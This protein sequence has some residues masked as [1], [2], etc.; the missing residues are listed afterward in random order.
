MEMTGVKNLTDDKVVNVLRQ[1]FEIVHV[2]VHVLRP[3]KIIQGW[4][5]IFIKKFEWKFSKHVS[6]NTEDFELL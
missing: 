6:K 1:I 4:N 3:S 5:N 2:D